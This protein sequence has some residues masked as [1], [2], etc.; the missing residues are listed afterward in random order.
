MGKTENLL[1]RNPNLSMQNNNEKPFNPEL[2]I[3]GWIIH[4]NTLYMHV[5][6]WVW[7]IGFKG[8]IIKCIWTQ[9]LCCLNNS[10]ATYTIYTIIIYTI[11]DSLS[12]FTWIYKI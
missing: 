5:Y 2:N 1:F 10:E 7:I 6:M 9:K 12:Q 3:T 11:L 8:S 4:M